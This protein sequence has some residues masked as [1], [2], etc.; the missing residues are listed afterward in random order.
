MWAMCTRSAIND[1]N[2]WVF[3]FC[4]TW[5]SNFLMIAGQVRNHSF[6]EFKR[7]FFK[8]QWCRVVGVS[9]HATNDR[10]CFYQVRYHCSVKRRSIQGSPLM[11]EYRW[12]WLQLQSA[13]SCSSLDRFVDDQLSTVETMKYCWK[14][15]SNSPWRSLSSDKKRVRLR[16]VC[17]VKVDTIFDIWRINWVRCKRKAVLSLF[18]NQ[19]HRIVKS[20]CQCKVC[21]W[22]LV[23]TTWTNQPVIS[24][25]S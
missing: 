18:C 5:L 9:S 16:N 11:G 20:R 7:P 1:L 6:Q 22:H 25:P 12:L 19:A 8:S 14:I 13:R 15:R 21:K 4:L 2:S 3:V 24:Q 10:N 23:A 17:L